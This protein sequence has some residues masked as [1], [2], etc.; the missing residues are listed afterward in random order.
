MDWSRTNRRHAVTSLRVDLR[1]GGEFSLEQWS[2]TWG[3]IPP[4]G[5]LAI[6]GGG[7]QPS[8]TIQKHLFFFFLNIH[9]IFR[10]F[11]LARPIYQAAFSQIGVLENKLRN[12]LDIEPDARVALSHTLPRI[13]QLV[14]E[15]GTTISLK[16]MICLCSLKSSYKYKSP[17][18]LN[19]YEIKFN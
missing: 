15:A 17:G 7:G 6:S 5:N 3:G 11:N 4:R 2:P 9:L 12:R 19:F 14:H 13:D 10:Y 8:K 18:S 16:P 1:G